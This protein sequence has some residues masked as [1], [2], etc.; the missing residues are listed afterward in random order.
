MNTIFYL[1]FSILSVTTSMWEIRNFKECKLDNIAL[2]KDGYAMLSPSIK[3]IWESPEAYI[4]TLLWHKGILYIGTGGGGKVYKLEAGKVELL[5]DTEEEG[6]LSLAV[7]KIGRIYAGT[8][9]HGKIFRDGKL[10]TSTDETYVWALVFD[11][12]GNLYAGTGITGKIFKIKEKGEPELYYE[13][14]KVNVSSLLY[15]D[16]LYAG[17]G[18]DGIV[19]KITDKGEGT[20]IYDADEPQIASLVLKDNTL[21][22]GATSDSA[23]SIY[24]LESDGTVSRVWSVRSTLHSILPEGKQLLVAAGNRLYRVDDEV[25]EMLYEFP[26][27]ISN[28]VDGIYIATGKMGKVY[29]LG[30]VRT[31][32]GIVESTVLDTRSMARWGKISFESYLPDEGDI[33]FETRSGNVGEPDNTWENW[34]KVGPDRSIRSYTARFIQWR[35]ILKTY[36]K[37]VSPKLK[38]VRIAYLRKN[39]KP[40]IREL[41]VTSAS[42]MGSM[43]KIQW[44]ALDEDGDS[45]T[46]NLYFK[47]INEQDWT[48]LDKNIKETFYYIDPMAFPDGEY[49]FKLEVSDSPSNPV[50]Q[51]LTASKTSELYMIDHTPPTIKIG[52]VQGSFLYFR[53]TDNLGY[54]SSCE[55]AIDGKGWKLLF[56][57]DEIF[58]SKVEN[59]KLKIKEGIHKIVIRVKDSYGNISYGEKEL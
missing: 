27:D 20:A 14:D 32:K 25:E 7:D 42:E 22:I 43:K 44:M 53:A 9:P 8:A 52:D 16:Y 35:A 56:P 50:D 12:K 46:F 49:I 15:R 38:M 39:K 59:F 45:L 33:S 3:A 13:T 11:G 40:E 34:V 6:V 57:D 36:N 18:E 28:I 4:W 47:R 54:I 2:D 1:L 24:E 31:A 10:F 37:R 19:F 48:L 55:Y 41:V 17:T 29:K 51:A 23:C 5:F 26:T 21:Y 58:D 30:S